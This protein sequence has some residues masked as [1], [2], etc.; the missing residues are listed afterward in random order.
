MEPSKMGVGETF[1]RF[2]E[3]PAGL[4]PHRVQSGEPLEAVRLAYELYGEINEAADN[5]VL[6]FHALTGSHHVS[7][8]TPSV[9][10]VDLWPDECQRGWW[11]DFVGPGL[12]IDTDV[13]AVLSI[14]YLGGCYG[15]TGPSSLN[16]A[17][18]VPYG[19][20]FPSLTL[21]DIV[22]SQMPLLDHLG[23]NTLHAVLGGSVGGMMCISLA[24][25][26]PE[27]VRNVIPISAGLETT[28]LQF[29]HNFEQT[30]AIMSDPNFNG[31]DYYS[32]ARPDRG[33]AL[34]R[35]IGHKTFVSLAAMDERARSAVI[36]E[37]AGPPGYEVQHPLESYIWYQGQKFLLRFDA[38]TYL[39]C[40][41]IWQHFDLLVEAGETK[42]T[43]LL[44]RCQNQ[45]YMVFSIDSDVCF[46]PEEQE[47]LIDELKKAG[48]PARRVTVHSDKGHDAF[49]LEPELFA[50]HLIDTLEGGRR[51]EASGMNEGLTSV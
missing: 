19:S 39:M 2:F 15:S 44:S 47:R 7:G 6:I 28:E 20:A 12:A 45:N 43:E 38:N 25:R 31:G 18:G 11:S 34:A 13:F 37:S 14:N 48:V 41:R 17:T 26:Y 10:G 16:P 24:T 8:F 30:V 21:A 46:Y 50:P 9:E 51:P 22:D 5:V 35:M 4:L 23:V 29:L 49:L 36:T 3:Y 32:G 33:L 27:R 42:M 40:M 1:T